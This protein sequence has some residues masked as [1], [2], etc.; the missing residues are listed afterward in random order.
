MLMLARYY[1]G[2]YAIGIIK[3][4]ANKSLV[5]FLEDGIIGNEKMGY[6]EVKYGE[7]VFVYT[8]CCHKNKRD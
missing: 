7:R 2:K 6:R 8:R 5:Y 1:M 4:V 3:T